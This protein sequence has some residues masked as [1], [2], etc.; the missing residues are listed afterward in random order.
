M[1][2]GSP[3]SEIAAEVE[4]LR[5]AF[6]NTQDL[7]REVCVLLFFRY[8]VTPTTN[9]LYQLVRKGSM[10]APAEA[11]NRFWK[12]LR[13]SSRVTL[14]APELPE[15][16]REAAGQLASAFWKG[17]QEAA[18]RS[19]HVLR[20]EALAQVDEARIAA[21]T[22]A[23]LAETRRLE[24]ERAHADLGLAAEAKATL[25]KQVETQ[26]EKIAALSTE[27]SISRH[28]NANLAGRLDEACDVHG[29][30]M[31]TVQSAAKQ[32]QEHFRVVEQ[33][34]LLDLER[35]RTQAAK[36]QKQLDA[37]QLGRRNELDKHRAA[38]TTLQAEA[39]QLRQA[40]GS[41]EGQLSA[42]ELGRKE[43]ATRLQ[44][45]YDEITALTER[46]VTAEVTAARTLEELERYQERRTAA[47]TPMDAANSDA[48]AKPPRRAAGKKS[49]V[50]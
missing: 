48:P 35:E 26:L 20:N 17:A 18:E 25:N 4:R 29:R 33:R 37:E 45:R 49:G 19:F 39:G 23:D 41:L 14:T 46:C 31:Q 24:L 11:L 2:D 16:F 28:E 32:A 50:T 42:A 8:G 30:E 38:V 47:D 10:S 3:E 1:S 34:F 6:P 22:V 9:R 44:D 40:I 7:Y 27:L 15:E 43:A 12:H 21:D 13:D 5:S 36:L